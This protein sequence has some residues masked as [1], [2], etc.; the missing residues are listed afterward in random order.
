MN[1]R[2]QNGFSG[3]DMSITVLIILLFIPTTFG[4]VYNLGEYKS[5]LNRLS[6]SVNLA[7]EIIEEAKAIT[8]SSI[9]LDEVEE[10]MQRKYNSDSVIKN[11]V[12]YKIDIT[13]E[14]PSEYKKEDASTHI[15][16]KIKVKITYPIG[17][18]TKDIEISKILK[19]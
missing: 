10:Y 9:D 8:Y 15:V 14:N 6:T 1:L 5:R 7:V 18:E 19:I 16:K 3:I 11:N 17:K 4:M 2:K 12:A 13:Y